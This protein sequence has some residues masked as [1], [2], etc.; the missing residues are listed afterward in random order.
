MWC[1]NSKTTKLADL[2][3]GWRIL[4]ETV[5]RNHDDECLYTIDYL[6]PVYIFAEPE[7][8]KNS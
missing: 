2:W 8:H 1:L 7:N 5:I 3:S 4:M 6:A